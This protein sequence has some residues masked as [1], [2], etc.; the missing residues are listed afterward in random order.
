MD[1]LSLLSRD[2]ISPFENTAFFRILKR[3][4]RTVR[5]NFPQNSKITFEMR[6]NMFEVI[7]LIS[8][9]ILAFAER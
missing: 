4:F 3:A 8:N 2:L 1:V 7:S 9:I 6:K 5:K